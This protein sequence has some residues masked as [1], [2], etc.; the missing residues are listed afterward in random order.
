MESSLKSDDRVLKKAYFKALFPIMFS[1]LGATVNALIDSAFVSQRLGSGGIAAVNLS[2]P[3]YLVIC[4]IGSLIAGGASVC[5][6]RC[7]GRGNMS[8]AQDYYRIAIVTSGVLSLIFTVVGVVF[9]RPIAAILSGGGALEEQVWQYCIV[10]FAGSAVS[11]MMILPPAYLQLEGKNKAIS[12]SVVLMVVSDILLDILLMYVFDFGLYGAAGASVI[13]SF[14]SMT[15]GFAALAIGGTNYHVGKVKLKLKKMLEILRYGS[16]SALVNLFDTVKLLLLNLI[17]ISAAGDDGAAVWAVVN[18]L[19]ELSLMIVMGVPRAATPMIVAYYTSMEN[20]GIRMLTKIEVKTGF[21]CSAVYA[22][23][24]TALSYPIGV[25]FG[26]EGDMFIPMLCLGIYVI[27]STLCTIWE[28]YFNSIGMIAEANISSGARNLVLPV[29]AASVTAMTGG[30]LWLFLPLSALAS[31]A[32]IAALVAA[33]AARSKKTDSPL[34]GVLLL[35]DRLERE[36]KILDFS[37]AANMDEACDAAEKIKDFC[38]AN[39]MSIKMT[40][41]LGLSIEELL[42]VIIQKTPE[43]GSID[44]RAFALDG[45]TGIRIR[46]VGKKYDPFRDSEDDD[47]F[48]MGVNMI[49]KMADLT[50]HVYTLGMNIITI[51]FPDKE[52]GK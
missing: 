24:I 23:M 25:F 1:V 27:L 4:T 2:M 9:C 41:K 44:L 50:T 19:S 10:T 39:D 22:V 42:N 6:S 5:S 3:I 33:A 15:Y 8:G 34:S 35:D 52:T 7:A 49:Q 26:I 36:Q 12:I 20:N 43:I 31:A 30:V 45:S 37:I 40:M 18:T 51:F 11:V 16:P 46:C 38:A 32:V 21:V 28:K 47:D 13:A 17:I 14:I 48:M 29:A